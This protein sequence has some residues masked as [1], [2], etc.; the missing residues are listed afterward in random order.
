MV[1]VVFFTQIITADSPGQIEQSVTRRKQD[2]GNYYDAQLL[3]LGLKMDEELKLLATADET[4]GAALLTQA[5]AIEEIIDIYDGGGQV[6]PKKIQGRWRWSRQRITAAQAARRYAEAQANIAERKSYCISRYKSEMALLKKNQKYA[7]TTGL[8]KYAQR[9]K[10]QAGKKIKKAPANVVKGI[11]YCK[12]KPSC[13]I[14]GKI[15]YVGDEIDNVKIKNIHRKQVVFERG[16]K[17]WKQRVGQK[18][19]KAW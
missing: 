4:E 2:I 6:Y 18:A 16:R 9:L 10:E 12:D 15:H 7:S 11:L 13:I 17:T 19:N 5:L 8:D 14:N 3:E 1:S